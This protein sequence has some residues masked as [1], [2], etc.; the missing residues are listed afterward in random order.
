MSGLRGTGSHDVVVADVFV[1]Q[2][3]AFVPGGPPVQSGPLYALPVRGVGAAGFAAVALGIARGAIDALVALAGAKPRTGTGILLR[4]QALV[5][6]QVAQAEALVGA[7]RAFLWETVGQ[8]WEAVSAG[9]ALS[10]EQRARLRLA[11]VQAGTSAAQAVDLL[12]AAG[13]GSALYTRSPLERAFRDVHA[14]TQ[15]STIQPS[16]YETVGRALLGV[17]PGGPVPL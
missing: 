12:W 4:E 5:Q 16:T 17:P 6:I 10:L 11:A 8:V 9:Q 14:V 13:G 7:G 1:P 3:H 15:Q 2:E